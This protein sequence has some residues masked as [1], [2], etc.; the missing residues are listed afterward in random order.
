MCSR[1]CDALYQEVLIAN[2]G[3][4]QSRHLQIDE[5]CESQNGIRDGDPF[6][7]DVI[8]EHLCVED[9]APCRMIS[10]QMKIQGSGISYRHRRQRCSKH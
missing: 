1:F 8:G 10:F 2:V 4:S 7:A 3:E 5:I 6:I 9:V